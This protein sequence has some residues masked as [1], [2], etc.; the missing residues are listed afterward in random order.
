VS[1]NPKSWYGSRFALYVN[2]AGHVV[3]SWIY[4]KNE[5]AFVSKVTPEEFIKK[6]LKRK[7]NIQYIDS[8]FINSVSP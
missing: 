6:Y 7:G 8:G 2:N 3:F 4:G 5:L 1:S